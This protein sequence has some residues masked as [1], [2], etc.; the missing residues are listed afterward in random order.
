MCVNYLVHTRKTRRI[1]SHALYYEH[2]FNVLHLYMFEMLF[3]LTSAF[4]LNAAE[5]IFSH[6]HLRRTQGGRCSII[7]NVVILAELRGTYSRCLKS[8]KQPLIPRIVFRLADPRSCNINPH[9]LVV[10]L[11]SSA[12]LSIAAVPYEVSVSQRPS[13]SQPC[14]VHGTTA[15]ALQGV[16]FETATNSTFVYVNACACMCVPS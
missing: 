14:G 11:I 2:V 13:S 5:G 8:Q 15:G 12:L 3:F 1:H 10:C 16:P 4:S 6:F 9:L 7:P